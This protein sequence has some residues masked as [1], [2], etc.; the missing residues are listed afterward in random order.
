MPLRRGERRSHAAQDGTER[1]VE[2]GDSEGMDGKRA[3]CFG[4]SLPFARVPFPASAAWIH[5]HPAFDARAGEPPGR[6]ALHRG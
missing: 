6:Y 1:E 5:Y 2:S 4:F 3:S